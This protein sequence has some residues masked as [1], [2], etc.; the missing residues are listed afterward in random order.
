[1]E[2][3]PN[4]NPGRD[5][6]GSTSKDMTAI[7]SISSAVNFPFCM[8]LKFFFKT[9]QKCYYIL[10][11]TGETSLA[12]LTSECDGFPESTVLSVAS[13]LAIA[14]NSLHDRELSY[15]ELS[16]D[17]VMV[18]NDGHVVLWREFDQKQYWDVSECVCSLQDVSCNNPNHR[19]R[20]GSRTHSFRELSSEVKLESIKDDWQALGAVLHSLLVGQMSEKK[21]K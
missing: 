2:A 8:Q 6:N 13:E 20:R 3:L 19:T 7:E 17:T 14:L 5:L 21:T 9:S 1:M 10:D 11:Y 16:L 12:S 18:D 4:N 15:G